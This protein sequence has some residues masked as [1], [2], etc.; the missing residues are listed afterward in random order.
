L[1]LKFWYQSYAII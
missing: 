1:L